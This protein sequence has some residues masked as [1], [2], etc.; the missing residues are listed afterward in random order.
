MNWRDHID[1]KPDVIGG[2]LRIKG[3]R[4]GVAFLLEL[5]GTGWTQEQVLESYPH[6]TA[7][8]LQAVFT[9]AAE[10]AADT[11]LMTPQ[12]SAA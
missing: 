10:A 9:F 2:K 12:R 4:I 11:R 8:D 5:L 6:L 3:T 7:T 1:S